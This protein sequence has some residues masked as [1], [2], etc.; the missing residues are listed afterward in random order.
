MKLNKV[1]QKYVK[2]VE[3]QGSYNVKITESLAICSYMSLYRNPS[4]VNQCGGKKT[5]RS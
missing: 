2:I 5:F 4:V 3:E 1:Y